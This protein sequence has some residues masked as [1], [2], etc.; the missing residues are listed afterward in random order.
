MPHPRRFRLQGLS[1]SWRFAPHRALSVC[2]T[3]QAPMG[4]GVPSTSHR[5]RRSAALQAAPVVG[6]PSDRPCVSASADKMVQ[7]RINQPPPKGRP[8]HLGV[9]TGSAATRRQHRGEPV[10]DLLAERC[11]SV[12]RWAR[13]LR[14]ATRCTGTP[15][16]VPGHQACWL[17]PTATR[18]PKATSAARN[19]KRLRIVDAPVPVS[20][21]EVRDSN[22]SAGRGPGRS[23][24]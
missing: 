14:T 1:P 23:L 5:S 7:D 16:P 21:S 22:R 15:F 17:D 12:G 6:S 8:A 9:P 19:R 20:P 4:F 11:P 10:P 13:A 18:S 3:R 24:S 2:F